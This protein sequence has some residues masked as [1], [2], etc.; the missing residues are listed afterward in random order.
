V[1]RPAKKEEPAEVSVATVRTLAITRATEFET[2]TAKSRDLVLSTVVSSALESEQA[3]S[4]L[5]V[6][7]RY[8]DQIEAER[9]KITGPLWEAYKAT[10]ALF[11]PAKK[12]AEEM[13]R[14]LKQAIG[15]YDLEVSRVRA[16]A[17]EE[18]AA[19]APPPVL[20]LPQ[21]AETREVGV[22]TRV[23]WK[24]RIVDPD[25]VERGLCSPDPAKIEAAIGGT[26]NTTRALV[27]G[28]EWYEDTITTVRR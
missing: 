24:W 7:A 11:D 13:I 17:M 15:A 28:V 6:L 26:A 12:R 10:N 9:K 23:V 2:A 22:S 19:G 18:Q 3:A 14:H 5:R 16:R 4:K 20:P 27:S 21:H 1:T 25:K 8:L